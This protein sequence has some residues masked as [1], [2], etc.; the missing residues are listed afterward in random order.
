MRQD[1]I[2]AAFDEAW[3]AFGALLPSDNLTGDN[4]LV[5]V[6]FLSLP[7]FHGFVECLGNYGLIYLKAERSVG[8]VIADQ[9][10]GRSAPCDW[11]EMVTTIRGGGP[12]KRVPARRLKG[13][14][15]KVLG[16]P[17]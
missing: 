9:H 11:A 4:E 7:D 14:R 12:A 13:N 5:G 2:V 17:E 6:G 1:R 3:D 8:V 15:L 10:F 16:L